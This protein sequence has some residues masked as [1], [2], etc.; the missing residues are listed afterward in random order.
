VA[1]LVTKGQLNGCGKSRR[2]QRKLNANAEIGLHCE[3]DNWQT[4]R[5]L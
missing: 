3:K 5:L 2:N 1:S 4:A